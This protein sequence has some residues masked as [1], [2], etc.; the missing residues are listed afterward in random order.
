M[1]RPTRLEILEYALEGVQT[2]LGVW[3]GALEEDEQEFYESHEEWL[4]Q[5]IQ[6]VKERQ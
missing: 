4:K 1:P 2:K 5:E 6:R 3:S